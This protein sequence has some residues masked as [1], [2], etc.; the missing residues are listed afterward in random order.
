MFLSIWYSEYLVYPF[1]NTYKYELLFM[2]SDVANNSSTKS[3][4]FYGSHG[5]R[6]RIR[7]RFPGKS[8]I[9]AT[10]RVNPPLN[11]FLVRGKDFANF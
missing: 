4:E 10:C 9:L 5:T 8:N 1:P 6:L 2:I 7:L 3:R 11:L